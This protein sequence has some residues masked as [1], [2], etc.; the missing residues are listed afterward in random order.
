MGGHVG[1]VDWLSHAT[2]EF[3]SKDAGVAVLDTKDI[4]D[5][6]IR[7][8]VARWES[9]LCRK[10]AKLKCTE[11]IAACFHEHV[12]PRL[13]YCLQQMDRTDV[14]QSCDTQ[15]AELVRA[16]QVYQKVTS[17]YMSHVA[18][19]SRLVKDRI[20]FMEM[21]D[22]ATGMVQFVPELADRLARRT[23]SMMKHARK[24]VQTLQAAADNVLRHAPGEEVQHAAHSHRSRRSHH[25]NR[26]HRS[27]DSGDSGDSHSGQSYDSAEGQAPP[28]RYSVPREQQSPRQRAR[29]QR[30][31]PYQGDAPPLPAAPPAINKPPAVRP[32]IIRVHPNDT[33]D[34]ILATMAAAGISEDYQGVDDE[35]DGFMQ[36]IS[37]DGEGS[38]D[39]EGSGEGSG[40]GSSGSDS[41]SDSG[42]SEAS[43]GTSRL[44][45]LGSSRNTSRALSPSSSEGVVDA[46]HALEAAIASSCT[47]STF[48]TQPAKRVSTAATLEHVSAAS[49]PPLLGVSAAGL[50]SKLSVASAA[51]S[52]ASS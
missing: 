12:P 8:S 15:R 1:D 11:N 4:D 44:E 42:S 18:H 28:A 17:D 25:S 5:D 14:V 35:M 30:T 31:L 36:E 22:K 51:A 3:Y 6:Q 40:D 2:Q 10:L 33:P 45:G 27:G 13:R 39:G 49:V 52:A 23:A 34:T 38:R 16:L 32:Y 9:M 47:V 43:M 19:M 48:G 24:N 41:E 26:S 21:V 50:A 20:E 37:D 46:P 7:A 29:P